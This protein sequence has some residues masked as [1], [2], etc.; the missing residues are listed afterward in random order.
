MQSGN[1]ESDLD[2]AK[3]KPHDFLSLGGQCMSETSKPNVFGHL[4]ARQRH[5]WIAVFFSEF[6]NFDS[7]CRKGM[8]EKGERKREI[9]KD[10]R[11]FNS[12]ARL[13]GRCFEGPCAEQGIAR[14]LEQQYSTVERTVDTDP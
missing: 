12:E 5:L 14:L 11:A 7:L 2:I 9:R 3:K 13:T 1:L 10:L 8:K 4:H 6:G